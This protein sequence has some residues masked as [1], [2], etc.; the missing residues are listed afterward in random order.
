MWFC[1]LRKALSTDR[2]MSIPKTS[3]NQKGAV[4]IPEHLEEKF[5][6][7]L[8]ELSSGNSDLASSYL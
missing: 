3:F 8:H 2:D 6:Y 1:A 5:T 7:N 4:S